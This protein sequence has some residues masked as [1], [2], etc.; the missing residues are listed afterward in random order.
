MQ[1]L[2]YVPLL[3]ALLLLAQQAQAALA[4]PKLAYVLRSAK[5]ALSTVDGSSRLSKDFSTSTDYA[6]N[7]SPFDLSAPTL[8]ENDDVV[9]LNFVLGV[10]EAG[11][12]IAAAADKKD[13]PALGKQHVPHQAFVVLAEQTQLDAPNAD[14][15]HVW[16]LTVKPST[17]RVSWSL[18]ADRIPANLLRSQSPLRLSLL[19]ANFPASSAAEAAYQPLQL[20]LMSLS[21]PEI[22]RLAAL[23]SGSPLSPRAKAEI[24]QGFRGLP[25]HRHTFAVPPAE[26]MPSKKISAVAAIITA[27]VPWLFLVS[28]LGIISPSL[29]ALT[30]RKLILFLGLA[31]L[32]TLAVQYWIGMTLFSMLPFL[33]AG[34]LFTIVV[35]RPALGELRRKRLATSS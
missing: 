28:A 23:E 7:H 18:R 30:A 26:T 27:V 35:G 4:Q 33:L 15:Q 24:E 1:P 10:E 17:G 16:P 8:L 6:L 3:A 19:I 14:A 22:L 25:E 29:E 9:R 13:L 5:L 32:E 31:G 20:P 12:K 21:P 34:G 11:K 2:S